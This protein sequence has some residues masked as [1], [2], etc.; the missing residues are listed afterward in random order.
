VPGSYVATVSSNSL[1]FDFFR[2]FFGK[3]ISGA[4]WG[5]KKDPLKFLEA[6]DL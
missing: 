6:L 4:Q 2:D 3:K 5:L 1:N